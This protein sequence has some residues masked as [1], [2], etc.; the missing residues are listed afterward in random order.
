LIDGQLMVGNSLIGS[1]LLLRQI[2]QGWT[3]DA[4]IALVPIET[5][6][7]ALAAGYDLTLPL[8]G[9][10]REVLSHLEKQAADVEFMPED[11]QAGRTLICSIKI[12]RVK[13]Q[14]SSHNP[15][16]SNRIHN[17]EHW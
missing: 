10:H 11:L 8:T 15:T 2:P 16:L 14:S 9:F 5:W 13:G 17:F 1:R 3:A 6:F 7:Q 12:Q 4:A